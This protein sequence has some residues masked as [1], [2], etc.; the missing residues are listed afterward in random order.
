[1]L[2][3]L[4]SLLNLPWLSCFQLSMQSILNVCCFCICFWNYTK[5]HVTQCGCRIKKSNQ[6]KHVRLLHCGHTLRWHVGN[7]KES[8]CEIRVFVESM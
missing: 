5:P 4:S 7:L 2:I 6:I 1:M 8:Y 3:M